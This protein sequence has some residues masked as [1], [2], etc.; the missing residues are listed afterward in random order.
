MVVEDG[1]FGGRD[2]GVLEFKGGAFFAANDDDIFAFYADSAGS[3]TGQY[4]GAC[5]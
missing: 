2:A 4:K 3:W 1:N 5:G